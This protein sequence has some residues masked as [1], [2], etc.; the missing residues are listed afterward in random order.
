MKKALALICLSLC[1]SSET[2]AFPVF[3]LTFF[4]NHAA[5]ERADFAVLG[6]SLAFEA[7]LLDH[8]RG[9]HFFFFSIDKDVR[10]VCPRFVCRQIFATASFNS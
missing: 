1:P 5:Q 10:G 9:L 7:T 8:L 3:P 6:I 2:I 4:A